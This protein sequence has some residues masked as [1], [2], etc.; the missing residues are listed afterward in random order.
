MRNLA[1]YAQENRHSE[2]GHE[3]KVFF[4]LAL[5]MVGAIATYFFAMD[6]YGIFLYES[7]EGSQGITLVDWLYIFSPVIL[8][9]AVIFVGWR[10]YRSIPRTNPAEKSRTKSR[11]GLFLLLLGVA[12]AVS[13]VFIVF[14]KQLPDRNLFLDGPDANSLELL[15]LMFT[16]P[17]GAL[18]AIFGLVKLF[19]SK[20][21]TTQSR[22]EPTA[23]PVE[24]APIADAD[25]AQEPAQI[26][27]ADQSG[28]QAQ[29]ASEYQTVYQPR[30]CIQVGLIVIA[31]FIGLNICFGAVSSFM[32]M[33]LHES[34][35]ILGVLQ[36]LAGGG[37]IFWGIRRLMK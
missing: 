7:E 32:N 15:L 21:I 29:V 4:S 36:S 33:S 1:R 31:M 34:W 30:S 16:L 25:K 37:I 14:F 11:T 23:K 22:A 18:F 13:P 19:D 20:N 12:I 2:L 10:L 27:N 6:I 5:M 35:G 28:D 24:Q 17:I 8:S 26:V 3:V 9:L